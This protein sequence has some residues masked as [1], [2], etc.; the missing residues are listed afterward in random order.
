MAVI[1]SDVL[2]CY[3]RWGFSYGGVVERGNQGAPPTAPGRTLPPRAPRR[4]TLNVP[5]SL[6]APA[7]APSTRHVR[8]GVCVGACARGRAGGGDRQAAGA[9]GRAAALRGGAGRG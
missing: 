8:R 4:P 3:R 9:D 1:S 5:P 7:S 2:A 6:P